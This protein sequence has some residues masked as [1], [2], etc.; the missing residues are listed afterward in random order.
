[1]EVEFDKEIDALL[2][3]GSG[4][5]TITI[6]EFAG[7]H[8][9][10]DEIAAFVERAMPENT[11][12]VLTNHFAECDPCR[13]VLSSTIL[14]GFEEISAP[15]RVNAA[16]PIAAVLPW[17]RRLFQF[18]Q[19]AYT[20]GGLVVLF[21]GFIGVSVIFNGQG[22]GAFEMSRTASN[23]PVSKEDQGPS[24]AANT[25]VVADGAT[26][27]NTASNTFTF[28]LMPSEAAPANT[29]AAKSAETSRQG[30]KLAEDDSLMPRPET[31]ATPMPDA[32]EKRASTEE[33][34]ADVTARQAQSNPPVRDN[35]TKV[36][37]LRSVPAAAPPAPA[38]AAPMTQDEMRDKKAADTGRTARKESPAGANAT[39]ADRKQFRG[40]TFEFRQGAWYDT[41]Y[42]GQGTINVRRNT[43]DYQKLDRGLRS[44]AENFIGTV[45][46]IWN[47]KA[48]KID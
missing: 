3:R 47:G 14:I 18:P 25:N 13:K 39:S 16:A 35:E 9:D 40:K 34:P 6:G 44:L 11:R 24:A 23:Q 10:A 32:G 29:S 5:R 8:P 12:A 30:P 26:S 33:Q 36:E 20:L 15:E 21:A 37:A 48:Y 41:T 22:D 19:L 45:V 28:P 46:T 1:M 38:K 27:A 17:Y 43:E 42:R 4:G 31:K 7:G 2:K